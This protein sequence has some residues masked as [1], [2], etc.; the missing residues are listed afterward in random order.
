MIEGKI[1]RDMAGT[2][3]GPMRGTTVCQDKN[4]SADMSTPFD[5]VFDGA[6]G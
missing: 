6:R 4:V 5:G 3:P 2:M 1:G